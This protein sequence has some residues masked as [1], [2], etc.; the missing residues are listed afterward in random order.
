MVKLLLG[1]NIIQGK[2]GD[3]FDF[4]V[5]EFEPGLVEMGLRTTD[6]WYTAYGDW[7]QIVAGIVA[8]DLEAM[9]QILT[10]EEWR[11]LKHRLLQ[12]VTDYTQKVI[13]ANGG[14]QL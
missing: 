8:G 12:H 5:Q 10:S 9:L 14:Y 11:G 6:V 7:P 3:H 4:F 13:P 1:W 2:E